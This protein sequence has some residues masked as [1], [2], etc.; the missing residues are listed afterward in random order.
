MTGDGNVILSLSYLHLIS[1]LSLSFY[2]R[3]PPF[4]TLHIY[5]SMVTI[6]I[7]PFNILYIFTYLRTILSVV[8]TY[9]TESEYLYTYLSYLFTYFSFI[10]ILTYIRSVN[11]TVVPTY[12]TEIILTY[13]RLWALPA[14]KLI[15]RQT[16]YQYTTVLHITYNNLRLSQPEQPEPHYIPHRNHGE[17][18]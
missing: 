18:P 13:I 1:I 12:P 9:P 15:S 8:P 17:Q 2:Y 4:L 6:L 5:I 16:K 7:T 3:H 14:P 10:V 11:I